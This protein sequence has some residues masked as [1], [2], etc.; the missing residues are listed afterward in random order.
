MWEGQIGGEILSA[1]ANRRVEKWSL[2]VLGIS[3]F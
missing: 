2:I 1:H 3:S